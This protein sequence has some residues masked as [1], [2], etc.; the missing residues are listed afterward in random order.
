[1]SSFAK[2]TVVGEGNER[3]RIAY[4]YL[5]RTNNSQELNEGLAFAGLSR[6]YNK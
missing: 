6:K 5:I 3:A 1:V 2:L 4:T